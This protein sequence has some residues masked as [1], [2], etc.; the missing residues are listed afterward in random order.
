MEMS[1]NRARAVALLSGALGF[2]PSPRAGALCAPARGG[3]PVG[4]FLSLRGRPSLV[5]GRCASNP[6]A[7]AADAEAMRAAIWQAAASGDQARLV[8]VGLHRTCARGAVRVPAHLRRPRAAV[9]ATQV[10]EDGAAVPG[11]IDAQDKEGK[12][13]LMLACQQGAGR[14][15]GGGAGGTVQH[16]RGARLAPIDGVCVCV[17][18]FHPATRA[19]HLDIVKSLFSARAKTN[20]Q[21]AVNAPQSA[22]LRVSCVCKQMRW[23]AR[24]SHGRGYAWHA[25]VARELC[26]T[27][28]R[29]LLWRIP[30][31]PPCPHRTPCPF[32]PFTT[33]SLSGARRKG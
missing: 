15:G 3:M 28:Q 20:L 23:P 17:R 9:L 13:A 19:G 24:G 32:P 12:S 31:S 8:Q 27:C 4:G 26:A 33:A 29:L 7:R 16:G 25:P 6:G 5:P 1:P 21:T 10:L 30:P 18:A 11:L 22:C 14:G 2:A